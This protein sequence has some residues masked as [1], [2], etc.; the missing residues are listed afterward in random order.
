[1]RTPPTPEAASPLPF[2]GAGQR[3]GKT[4]SAVF[5]RIEVVHRHVC[6]NDK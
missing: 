4:G 5:A 3:S 6:A 1:M 2:E